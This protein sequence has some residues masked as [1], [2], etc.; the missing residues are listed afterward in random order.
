MT[1]RL[2]TRKPGF[3]PLFTRRKKAA[4]ARSRRFKCCLG[5][6]QFPK[7]PPRAEPRRGW[8]KSCTD[9]NSRRIA[10]P[11]ASRRCALQVAAFI[12]FALVVELGTEGLS[13][14]HRRMQAKSKGA[15]TVDLFSH[16]QSV[17]VGCHIKKL[18][19]TLF[20]SRVRSKNFTMR[21]RYL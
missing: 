8:S 3:S 18:P 17:S 16:S 1:C 11:S 9:R 14:T 19:R 12:E 10:F 5:T 15:N 13:L 4:Y 21:C 7:R 6:T 2:K 20:T